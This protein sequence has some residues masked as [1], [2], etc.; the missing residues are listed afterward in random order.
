MVRTPIPARLRALLTVW[1]CLVLPVLS[2]CTTVAPYERGRLAKPDMKLGRAPDARAGSE[3]ALAYREGST[4]S[5]G[6]SGGGCGC[7]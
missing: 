6:T 5:M 4:G 1:V 3:H 7:N 2:A